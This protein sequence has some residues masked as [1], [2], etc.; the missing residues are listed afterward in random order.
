MHVPRRPPPMA[1]NRRSP[2]AKVVTAAAAAAAVAPSKASRDPSEI[3]L[4]PN[5][6]GCLQPLPARPLASVQ[7][8]VGRHWAR[9]STHHQGR[10]PPTS[11]EKIVPKIILAPKHSSHLTNHTCKSGESICAETIWELLTPPE[12]RLNDRSWC[13]IQPSRQTN[14]RAVQ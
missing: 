6:R 4:H 5:W 1:P 8:E 7:S 14:G 13:K 2:K 9:T 3:D 12:T 10:P 11:S